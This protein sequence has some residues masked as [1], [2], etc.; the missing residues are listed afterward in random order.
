MVSLLNAKRYA[1]F[2]ENPDDYPYDK[3]E[4]LHPALHRT[5]TYR[6]K[7]TG[8]EYFIDLELGE[9]ECKNGNAWMWDRK[10][11][12][13]YA[14]KYCKHKLK[15][16]ASAIDAAIADKG[17]RWDDDELLWTYI[18]ATGTRYNVWEVVSAFH[19]ELRRA[20][21]PKAWFWGNILMTKRGG[22]GL[23]KYMLNI[24]Y[25]ETRDHE[26]ADSLIVLAGLKQPSPKQL[27]RHIAWFCASVK[28][29][30]L[31]HRYEVFESEMAGYAWLVKNYGKSVAKGGEIIDSAEYPKL[32]KRL[33]SGYK[34]RDKAKFQ[35]GLKG[36]QKMKTIGGQKLDDHRVDLFNELMQIA[37]D[38]GEDDAMRV[39]EVV[40]RRV[41]KGFPI[42]Y[43]E[44]NAVADALMGETYEAGLLP[45]KDRKHALRIPFK[46]IKRGHFP[47]IPLYAQDNHTWLGKGLLRKHPEQLQPNVKQ[48]NLD[49][50]ICGAYYGVC[51][52]TL[53]YKQFQAIDCEWHEVNWPKHLHKT[54]SDLWY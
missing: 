38:F 43:H 32:R 19:K 25:E 39:G 11:E 16:M 8:I 45:K 33:L 53:A 3:F 15:L 7:V 13:Y 50:R 1:K 29:W 27:H 9:C 5:G 51:W 14:N 46:S 4:S 47:N 40:M 26:L 18:K 2:P 17:S 49:F 42:G 30:E 12:K 20:D 35:S 6:D 31:D 24:I 22:K 54:V 36:I 48:K 41:N 21:F 10:G 44:I 37:E 28:K 52:R 34:K 23:A